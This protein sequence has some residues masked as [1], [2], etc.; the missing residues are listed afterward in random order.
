MTR[1][2]HAENLSHGAGARRTNVV[3]GVAVSA[4]LLCLVHCLALP[5]L[6]LLLPGVLGL[7]AQSDA[8]HYAALALVVPAG[9]AAFWL[10][11]RRHRARRPAL[12]GIAGVICLVIA[13]LPGAGEGGELWF[14][15]TG[16]LLL[17]IGH[18]LNW[19]LRTH[20]A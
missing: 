19:R 11:Y 5:L 20:A 17:V 18:T 14:T 7:F 9:L 3:E 1:I 4:S 6:L 13:L 2:M 15:V 16:S 8:F 10:G 12:L